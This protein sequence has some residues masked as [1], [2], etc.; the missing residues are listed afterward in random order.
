MGPTMRAAIYGRNAPAGFKPP[1][2]PGS[3]MG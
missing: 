2:C 3:A 1:V